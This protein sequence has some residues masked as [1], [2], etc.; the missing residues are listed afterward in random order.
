MIQEV[1]SPC[2]SCKDMAYKT[3]LRWLKKRIK[4]NKMYIAN[5]DIEVPLDPQFVD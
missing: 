3:Y 5:L 2:F 1:V 4:K